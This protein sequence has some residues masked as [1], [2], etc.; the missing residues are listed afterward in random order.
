[1]KVSFGLSSVHYAKYTPGAAGALGTW[2]NPIAIPGAVTFTPEAQGDS[3][4][5]YADNSNYYSYTTDNGDAGDLEMAYFP[6]EFL[7]DVLGWIKDDNG[8]LLELA[9]QPQKPFALLF[10][11]QG[12][13]FDGSL[14]PIRQVYYNVTGAKPSTEYSTTEEGIEVQTT[15]MPITCATLTFPDIGQLAKARV[16]KKDGAVYDNFFNAVYTPAPLTP[17]P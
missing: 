8:V 3:Y 11:V 5:F 4:T 13:D 7:I 16:T 17:T 12:V 9:G 15:T 2:A 6:D 1:M 14:N 10:E